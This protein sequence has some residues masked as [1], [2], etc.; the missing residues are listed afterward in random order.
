M[1]QNDADRG[2]TRKLGGGGKRVPSS[3]SVVTTIHRPYRAGS[4]CLGPVK[5]QR[6]TAPPSGVGPVQGGRPHI[7]GPRREPQPGQ[8]A[9]DRVQPM[10]VRTPHKWGGWGSESM[11][12]GPGPVPERRR[13]G[14]KVRPKRFSLTG[15]VALWALAGEVTAGHWNVEIGLVAH[16]A[17]GIR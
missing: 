8:L 10:L 13:W 6:G 16:S 14:R 15:A 2:C 3:V 11:R 17:T 5:A 12:V 9:V 4:L 7:T 1:P